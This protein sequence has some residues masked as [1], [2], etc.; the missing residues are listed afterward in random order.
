MIRSKAGR[1]YSL[2][3]SDGFLLCHHINRCCAGLDAQGPNQHP[4][5]AGNPP[6]PPLPPGPEFR[7]GRPDS[8]TRL[9]LLGEKP[10]SPFCSSLKDFLQQS[11]FPLLQKCHGYRT[12]PADR[13]PLTTHDILRNLCKL[14]LCNTLT[15]L[16]RSRTMSRT[17]RSMSQTSLYLVRLQRAQRMS[18]TSRYCNATTMRSR[19]YCLS[20]RTLSSMS[21]TRTQN[22][23]GTR[24][25]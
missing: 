12:I 13:L 18:L 14:K 1:K 20:L 2:C 3:H 19:R 21:S 6:P 10:L 11:P 24:Q 25:E 5:R 23:H 16:R 7:V 9:S 4:L 15:K 22:Q 8:M 17:I